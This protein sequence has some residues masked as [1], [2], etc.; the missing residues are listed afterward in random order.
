MKV[1]LYSVEYNDGQN[2]TTEFFGEHENKAI[3]YFK[4]QHA[5]I[6]QSFPKY[7]EEVRKNFYSWK[8]NDKTITLKLQ[9]TEVDVDESAKKFEN[10]GVVRAI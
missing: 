4:I 9:M 6:K 10:R 3:E 1:Q 5:M 8:N 7:E 2:V